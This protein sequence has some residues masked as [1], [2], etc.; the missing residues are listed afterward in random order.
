MEN[1]NGVAMWAALK[2]PPWIARIVAATGAMTILSALLPALH[3]RVDMVKTLLPD[4]APAAATT[5]ALATG[6]L[7][8]VLSRPLRRGKFRAW[9]LTAVLSALTV[10]LHLVKGL[11]VEEAVVT[12][13]MFVLL[14]S[15]RPN[16]TARP[17]HRSLSR[18]L[19]VLLGGPVLATTL[20][21][22]W[23][24]LDA[25]GQAPGTTQ[26][27]R[28]RHA[29]V[30]LV[31]ITGPVQF[32][33]PSDADHAAIAL[34]TLG[35]TVAGLLVLALT[36]PAGGPHPLTPEEDQQVRALLG[37]WGQVDS[38]SYFATRSDR[39]VIFSKSGKAAVT[40][41]V[42][43]SVSL[44]AGDPV[45]DP[46]AW[47]GAI[48]AW[49]CEAKSFG[50]VPA[51]LG[52]GEVG[53]TAFHR[54]GLDALEL[55]D[56]AIVQVS[57][58]SLEGRS[59]RG[60]RQAV[61]RCERAGLVVTCHRVRDLDEAMRSEIRVRA[62][63]WRDGEVERGFSM[64]LGRFVDPVDSDSL[65]VLCRDGDGV[66]RGLLNFVP[67]GPDG[68]SLDLMRRDR[69]AENGIV[70]HMVVG[71]WR[72]CPELGV[73]RFSLNFAVFRSVFARGDRLGAGPVL[74]L[75]R[76]LLL[77]ASRFWQIESLYRANAKYRPSWEPRFLCF[78]R[79]GDLPRIGTA[80]LRAEAFLVAPA[81]VQRVLARR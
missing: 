28:V 21:W 78:A 42:V 36:M 48:D 25:D 22:L 35:A 39:S 44:A 2:S 56:E 81:W 41:R 15:A 5:G 67:W 10:V 79:P 80:A 49:L 19:A 47:A 55:G 9:L 77:T 4:F 12:T 60:V 52:V 18:V 29:F 45:G 30:G 8:L 57:D 73:R 66:L 69:A 34:L 14:V 72:A 68:L 23:L 24:A 43:G 46:E 17:D 64:A 3:G 32:V 7:L 61:S 13:A 50:W 26:L 6:T 40:Y 11:D 27:D 71:L 58:F 76:S 62:E 1:R 20:G 75:W 37:C 16:F 33:H 59:M 63:E 54:A 38:L 53:A 74:R 70:E 65:V 31:G 51:A